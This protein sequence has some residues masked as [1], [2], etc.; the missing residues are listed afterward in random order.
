MNLVFDRSSEKKNRISL[1]AIKGL[2]TC[3]FTTENGEVSASVSF[4]SLMHD[5]KQLLHRMLILL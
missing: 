4:L 5:G 1:A 2:K 3:S